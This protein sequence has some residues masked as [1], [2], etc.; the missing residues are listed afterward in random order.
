MCKLKHPGSL[1]IT[2]EIGDQL[3]AIRYICCFWVDHLLKYF[4]R[5]LIDSLS[6]KDYAEDG[7][8]VQQFLSN[9]FYIGSRPAVVFEN[10]IKEVEQFCLSSP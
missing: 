9:I 3:R 10:T 8:P 4:D 5:N 7:E 2:A 1:A 6:H